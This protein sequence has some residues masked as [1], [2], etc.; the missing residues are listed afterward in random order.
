M[1]SKDSTCIRQYIFV[2]P[3]LN[4]HVFSTNYKQH[5][6]ISNSEQNTKSTFL[7]HTMS[8]MSIYLCYNYCFVS[9]FMSIWPLSTDLVLHERVTDFQ[10]TPYKRYATK[11]H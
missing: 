11:D 1:R 10:K 3:S 4:P 8:I 6:S 2:T 5:M 9:I 7:S